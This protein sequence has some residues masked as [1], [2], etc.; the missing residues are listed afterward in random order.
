MAYVILAL[1]VVPSVILC[2]LAGQGDYG[3]FQMQARIAAG[4]YT[5]RMRVRNRLDDDVL[6]GLL[7]KSGLKIRAPQ[8]HYFRI[9]LTLVFAVFGIVGLA[10]G[11]V[12]PI[13][14]PILAWVVFE[15]RRPFPMYYG[16][17]WMQKQAASQRDRALYLLYR[18]LLQEVVAFRDRPIAVNEMLRRQLHRVPV[19]QPFLQRCLD[20]WLDDPIAALKR[21]GEDVGTKQAKTFAHMLMEIEQAGIGVALDVFQ[22]NH[23]GFRT[24]RLAAFRAQLNARAL[25]GTALTLIGLGAASYDITVVI[26]IYTGELLKASFGG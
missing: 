16:F 4:W 19:L 24:E 20:E 25:L 17:L 10:K 18:L 9:V 6:N 14:F 15:Y 7:R 3:R 2:Y 26:Q 13:V 12:L 21:F 22:N 11:H 1:G 8:Y 5:A 23:E